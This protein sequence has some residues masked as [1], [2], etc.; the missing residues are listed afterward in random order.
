[1][2]T[3]K[4]WLGAALASLGAGCG[5]VP[6]VKDGLTEPGAL[7]FNGYSNP[8]ADCYHCHGGDGTGRFLHGPDLYNEVPGATDAEISETIHKGKSIMPAYTGKLSDGEIDTLTHWLR[9]KF[10]GAPAPGAAA[11][12]APAPAAAPAPAPA[13]A[14]KS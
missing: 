3:K 12:P 2:L 1:M 14:P 5:G 13:E 10:G 8:N 9:G 11:A 6:L 7:L 4:L